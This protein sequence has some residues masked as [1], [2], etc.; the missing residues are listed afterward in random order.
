MSSSRRV[1]SPRST[2]PPPRRRSAARG[3]SGRRGCTTSTTRISRSTPRR[4]KRAKVFNAICRST[5]S[6]VE[7]DLAKIEKLVRQL[8]EELGEDPKREGLV[9]TPL[10][11]AQALKFLTQGYRT[12]PAK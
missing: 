2:Y 5:F 7:P 6:S 11:V 12:E 3:R 4:L 9:K 1:C 8:L 10:R